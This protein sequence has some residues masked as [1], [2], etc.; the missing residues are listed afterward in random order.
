MS[1]QTNNLISKKPKRSNNSVEVELQKKIIELL[2]EDNIEFGLLSKEKIILSLNDVKS[3]KFPFSKGDTT[4]ESYGEVD[5]IFLFKDRENE[6]NMLMIEVKVTDN[7]KDG[8]YQSLIYPMAIKHYPDSRNIIWDKIKDKTRNNKSDNA[9]S[10]IS[11]DDF[12]SIFQD[13]EKF[14]FGLLDIS[15][16]IEKM[17]LIGSLSKEYNVPIYYFGISK[18]DS[19]H[20]SKDDIQKLDLKNTEIKVL[21]YKD[22]GLLDEPMRIYE[23]RDKIK[24]EIINQ[25]EFVFAENLFNKQGRKTLDHYT[26]FFSHKTKEFFQNLNF[27]TI[28]IKINYDKVRCV[29]GIYFTEGCNNDYVK[30]FSTL[31]FC[32]DKKYSW[33]KE[34]NLFQISHEDPDS[35][36]FKNDLKSIVDNFIEFIEGKKY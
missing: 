10:F 31:C 30:K 28:D 36:K 23:I 1:K 4:R 22:F 35:Q 21:N 34:E 18:D 27:L 2:I 25:S 13:P 8:I 20:H 33:I 12:G 17:I 29:P 15:P 5:L 6:W 24:Q 19:V 11:E 9:D 14:H 16:R 3:I 7:P 32:K 26:L